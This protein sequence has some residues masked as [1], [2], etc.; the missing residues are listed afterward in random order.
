MIIS[1]LRNFLNFLLISDH[2]YLPQTFT[3]DTISDISLQTIAYASNVLV[4]TRPI[5]HPAL[6]LDPPP[7]P[8]SSK[9]LLSS[10]KPITTQPTSS[11]SAL[12]YNTPLNT[13]VPMNSSPITI[14]QTTSQIPE[15]FLQFRCFPSLQIL[16]SLDLTPPLHLFHQISPLT[17]TLH[18]LR[19]SLKI[20]LQHLL[21]HRFYII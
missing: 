8:S 9:S 7:L 17:L 19:P 5:G 4:N 6:S 21:Y 11:H 15:L 12:R 14:Q 18:Y 3:S 13:P 1:V 2:T 10:N 16:L 20:L